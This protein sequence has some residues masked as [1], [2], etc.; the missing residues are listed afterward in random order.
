MR[1]YNYEKSNR[2]SANVGGRFHRR[3][4][5]ESAFLYKEYARTNKTVFIIEGKDDILLFSAFFLEINEPFSLS[6]MLS[7]LQ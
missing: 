3:R 2:S 5:R 6:A 4:H 1:K 7:I